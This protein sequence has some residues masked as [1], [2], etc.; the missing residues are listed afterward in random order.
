LTNLTTLIRSHPFLHAVLLL[1]LLLA[2]FIAPYGEASQL[3]CPVGIFYTSCSSLSSTSS[4]I[5]Y[6]AETGSSL[7]AIG[8]F[9]LVILGA[10]LFGAV[11]PLLIALP[12][13]E[14]LGL[15]KWTAIAG[16]VC[17]LAPWGAIHPIWGYWLIT[18]CLWASLGVAL[19]RRGDANSRLDTAWESARIH[20]EEDVRREREQEVERR[21]AQERAYQDAASRARQSTANSQDGGEAYST[22]S[23]SASTFDAAPRKCLDAAAVLG[24]RLTDSVDVIE[25]VYRSWAKSLHPDRNPNPKGA[26]QQLKRINNARDVL[27][28]YKRDHRK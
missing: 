17:F 22:R 7:S 25:A 1:V 20:A 24:V 14:G 16:A 26:E 27:L 28:E 12:A 6:V 2:I 8:V 23:E 15:T 21:R 19:I 5:G 18:V 4:L 10:T 13:S 9:L 3:S 11:V